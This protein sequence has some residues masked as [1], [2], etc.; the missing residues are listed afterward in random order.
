MATTRIKNNAQL[1]ATYIL[2]LSTES[3]E[4]T[5]ECYPLLPISSVINLEYLLVDHI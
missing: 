1:Q 3:G 4:L 2:L 5:V